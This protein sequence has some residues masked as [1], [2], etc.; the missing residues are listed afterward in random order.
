M[1]FLCWSYTVVELSTCKTRGHI[2]KFQRY[3]DSLTQKASRLFFSQQSLSI[4]GFWMRHDGPSSRVEKILALK[5]LCGKK[6][7]CIHKMEVEKP[8]SCIGQ[9]TSDEKWDII[10]D[11]KYQIDMLLPKMSRYYVGA[12]YSFPTNEQRK[13]C[14][15]PK[16]IEMHDPTLS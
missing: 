9:S 12:R 1:H 14:W 16:K 3:F 8:F 4:I 2:R 10:N 11:W 5:P 13:V 7:F 6:I 15:Q